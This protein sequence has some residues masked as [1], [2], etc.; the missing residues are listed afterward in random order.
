LSCSRRRNVPLIFFGINFFA[1][2]GAGVLNLLS[3]HCKVRQD[4]GKRTAVTAQLHHRKLPNPENGRRA[5]AMVN[6]MRPGLAVDTSFSRHNGQTPKQVLLY[7]SQTQDLGFDSTGDIRVSRLYNDKGSLRQ[8]EG[9][10]RVHPTM[11]QSAAEEAKLSWGN[12]NNVN[13]GPY[14]NS[15]ATHLPYHTDQMDRQPPHERLRG[16]RPPPLDLT[17]GTSPS[18]RALTFGLVVPPATVQSHTSSLASSGLYRQQSQRRL[19]ELPTPTIVL[20]PAKEDFDFT[21]SPEEMKHSSGY[22]PPSS[23]YS[24]YTNY[25]STQHQTECTAPV[26]SIPLFTR[27]QPFLTSARTVFDE[28]LAGT[29]SKSNRA[30]VGSSVREQPGQKSPLSGTFTCQPSLPASRRSRGWWNV[31]LSPFST[32]PKSN[33]FYWRSP[34][35]SEAKEDRRR[36]L[37]DGSTMNDH[38]YQGDVVFTDRAPGDEELRTALP[39]ETG[40]EKPPV[41]KRSHTAPG[42]L[43]FGSNAVKIYRIPSQGSAAA[44][45][46]S[47]RH[48]PSL[49]VRDVDGNK[50]LDNTTGWNASET[51][52]R[53]KDDIDALGA[54]GSTDTPLIVDRRTDDRDLENG[55]DF[56]ILR[57]NKN[58]IDDFLVNNEKNARSPQHQVFSTPSPEELI[59]ES[60]QSPE[61]DQHGGQPLESYFSPLSATPVVEDARVATFVGPHIKGEGKE[62]QMISRPSSPQL[63]RGLAAATMA[64]RSVDHADE[65]QDQTSAAGHDLNAA[66]NS[67]ELGITDAYVGN[68]KR[69]I[70]AWVSGEGKAWNSDRYRTILSTDKQVLKSPWYHRFAWILIGGGAVSLLL[71]TMLV[72]VFIPLKQRDMRVEAEWLNLT[73]FPPLV[74]GIAT[75]IKSATVADVNGCVNPQSIWSCNSPPPGNQVNFRF[76]IRFRNGTMPKNETQIARRGMY[77]ANPAIPSYN[78]QSFIG[79]YTDN[80]TAPYNGESTPFYISLLNASALTRNLDSLDK[81]Q[82][83]P[84]PYPTG[85]NERVSSNV[86]TTA[87]KT[88]PLPLLDED[89]C[90]AQSTLYPFAAAQTLHLYNRGESDEHYG[91]YTYFDRTI[92]TSSLPPNASGGLEL[93]MEGRSNVGLANATSVCTWS[94]TRLRLQI[95]TRK[96][97]V[98][99]L[100]DTMSLDGLRAINST[101]NDMSAPGSFPMPVTIS[102]VRPRLLS[103]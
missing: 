57:A 28:K 92:Y 69:H 3:S 55:A 44:Y 15:I 37:E 4:D 93:D 26:P 45:Y 75:V 95:W 46:D 81:R 84:Y 99:S 66:S 59:Y 94:Q 40:L 58:P 29:G 38:D 20:T 34:S 43:D 21:K 12:E 89:G 54:N 62:V 33:A 50:S 17:P 7:E 9:Q 6:K 1:L 72:I 47:N 25:P 13:I 82:S 79:E 39:S 98:I 27:D 61:T 85:S 67:L 49:C 83:D 88:I 78:D 68:E 32:A 23:V 65:V 52:A 22:R 91:F 2:A 53:S 8:P 103:P 10:Y 42:A 97:N 63:G 60:P 71:L 18:D 80:V 30:F 76:E 101:A 35:L 48:F 102:L 64:S 96:P 70:P 74:T 90:P 86:S 77:S 5:I 14:W 31:L 56:T 19:E 100:S 24:R 51:A 41:P 87:P 73:A 11:Q 36:I 16:L